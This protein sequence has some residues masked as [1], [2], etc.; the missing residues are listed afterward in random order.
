MDQSASS[1]KTKQ[2][3]M[4]MLLSD[5]GSDITS[6]FSSAV[7][8]FSS[9]LG[10]DL[11]TQAEDKPSGENNSDEEEEEKERTFNAAKA[12]AEARIDAPFQRFKIK[13]MGRLVT[14]PVNKYTY[15]C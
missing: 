6:M 3:K 7:S 12:K 11:L 4:S 2:Q 8:L 10:V 1:T 9:S 14:R 13:A 5:D 15:M